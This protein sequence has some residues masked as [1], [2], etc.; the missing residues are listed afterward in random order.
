LANTADAKLSGRD[1]AREGREQ[2]ASHSR[3]SGRK[4][5]QAQKVKKASPKL[6]EQVASGKMTL[7]QAARQ[8]A[9]EAKRK[10]LRRK[11]AAAEK[12]HREMELAGILPWEIRHG[13]CLEHLAA[14]EPESVPLIF[15]DPPYNIGVDYG[16]GAKADSLTEE[17]YLH[18]CARW[19]ELCY[20]ALAPHGSFWLL[21]NHENAA[22]LEILLT[23]TFQYKG[24]MSRMFD[25][26]PGTFLSILSRMVPSHIRSWPTWY[27]TFG[28]NCANNFKRC[29]RRLLYCV[30]D[31]DHFTFN[32]DAVRRPSDRQEKYNDRRADPQGKI[33]DDVWQIPRLTGTATER[34]PGFPTQLPLELLRYIVGCS[35]NPGDLVLDPF[36]G[37]APTGAVC[38]H[39][40]R[41]FIGIEKSK[42][43]VD[44]A[45][46]TLKGGHPG[47]A[48]LFAEAK[49][50]SGLDDTVPGAGEAA[51]ANPEAAGEAQEAARAA[52]GGT[53]P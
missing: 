41:R 26:A 3:V 37:S 33:M 53:M 36:C 4:V 20:R 48:A 10:E 19:I 28:V 16:E 11:A 31:P 6:Y 44:L 1:R 14:L 47:I 51:R 12:K 18:W 21:I 45:T 23:G 46:L 39:L 30:K 24:E 27:E 49:R 35:S 52:A 29:S 34:L 5:Q 38:I 15:A 9:N 22:K 32:A 40:G 50:I 2:A 43:Y 25:G 42:H 13:D 17:D 7:A 8:V